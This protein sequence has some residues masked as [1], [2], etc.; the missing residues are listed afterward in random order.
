MKYPALYDQMF[1][2]KMR[3]QSLS[4]DE[5]EVLQ[6]GNLNNVYTSP[7]GFEPLFAEAAAKINIFRRYATMLDLGSGNS[8]IT[9]A[10]TGTAAF[11]PENG[12]ITAIDE[13]FHDFHVEPHKLASIVK[14]KT[15]FVGDVQFDLPQ[16][17]AKEF[18]KRFGKAE[19]AGFIG[20]DGVSEPTGI[21]SPENGAQIGVTVAGSDTIAYDDIIKLYFSLDADYRQNAV[22]LMNDQTAMLLR[23][24]KDS[25]ENYL[26][27]SSDDKIFGRPVETTP[28][29]PEIGTGAKPVAF[30]DLSY[31]WIFRRKAF[32]IVV[33][34]ETYLLTEH[35]IGFVASERIDGRLISPD[36]VKLLQMAE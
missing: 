28:H 36:A 33:L 9:G 34:R 32:D 14:L 4:Q 3:N 6:D 5:I 17:L 11:V 21:L 25:T 18:G 16:C 12:S 19:E 2:K 7:D 10:F 30:G 22:W 20:G 27:R 24:M 35:A 23:T 13:A 1:W 29:M 15:N 31:Y 8:L 26:W